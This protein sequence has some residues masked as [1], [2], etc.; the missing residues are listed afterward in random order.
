MPSIFYEIFNKNIKISEQVLKQL[1]EELEILFE[2]FQEK[3]DIDYVKV[4]RNKLA[5]LLEEKHKKI[6]KKT[7]KELKNLKK[8]LEEIN[9]Y[10]KTQDEEGKL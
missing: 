3:H 10:I 5:H 8:F 6:D 2:K 7:E 4:L 9:E 1:K